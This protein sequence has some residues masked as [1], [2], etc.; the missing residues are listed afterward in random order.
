MTI[1]A[2]RESTNEIASPKKFNSDVNP[3]GFT[4]EQT[5]TITPNNTDLNLIDKSK[6]FYFTDSKMQ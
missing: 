2:N 3:K 6:N 4:R 5:Q 1:T